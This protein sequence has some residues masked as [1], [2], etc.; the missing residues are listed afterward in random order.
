M[1]ISML[2]KEQSFAAPVVVRDIIAAMAPEYLNTVL[3][4]FRGGKALEEGRR[5]CRYRVFAGRR[6][7]RRNHIGHQK[8]RRVN[9]R[10]SRHTAGSC[11]GRERFSGGRLCDRRPQ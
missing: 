6:D 10:D 5:R 2:G 11:P 4:C 8:A 1:I 7:H 9:V 3:G